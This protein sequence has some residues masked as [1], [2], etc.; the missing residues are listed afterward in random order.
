M[1]R[2]SEDAPS[3]FY[4]PE[5]AQG[6][7][8]YRATTATRGP[9]SAEHQH[10]GPPAALLAHALERLVDPE[11]FRVAR[12]IFQ[13]L[14]PIPI[15]PVRVEAS[16]ERD[17]KKVK[18]LRARMLDADGR[19]LV[20]ADATVVRRADVGVERTR[21]SAPLAPPPASCAPFSFP[22]FVASAG[23]Q[24]AMEARLVDGVWG[25]GRLSLWMR[26]VVPLLP[27]ASP[28]A[29]E[30]VVIVADSGNGL[31]V[32]LDT[33]AYTFVNPELTVHLSAELEGEWVGLDAETTFGP[34]GIGLAA[35]RIFDAAGAL[36]RGAQ[37]LI[38]ER[39]AAV[40]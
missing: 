16:I 28:S 9:W 3:S 27:G 19:E 30:R 32:A 36:G 18:A 34:D 39:R 17:G 2:G 6:G 40:R 1:T 33:A 5:G 25:S 35:T 12:A 20:T 22:F 15:A 11:A 13:F 23:Y 29:L 10:G 4:V 37:A 14:R 21:G 38:V 8:L 31:G 26:M 24:T 7:G